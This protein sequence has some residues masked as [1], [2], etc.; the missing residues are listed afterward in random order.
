MRAAATAGIVR[1]GGDAN[2]ADLYVLFKESDP[3]PVL[4]ALRELEHL[5]TEASTQL[6]ARLMHRPQPDVQR[7]AAD[8]LL[9][10]GARD[11]APALKSFLD[12]SADPA[13]R[14]RALVAADDA[15]LQ[16]AAADPRMSTW[17]FRALLSRGQPDQAADWFIAHG[18]KLSPAEAGR[19]DGRLGDVCAGH[20]RERAG[21]GG[22]TSRAAH[23]G[24][25][26]RRALS[27]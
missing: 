12:P 20:A 26:A 10:R 19:R 15:Q 21:R 22:R 6:I 18:A 16:A 13:M 11:A 2:L 4:S 7:L 14:G 25:C 3:R 23:D 24:G 5:Q 27:R 9:R 17:A 8:I 1:A